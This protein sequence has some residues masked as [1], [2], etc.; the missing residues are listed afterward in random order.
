LLQ[1]AGVGVGGQDVAGVAELFL[2]GFQVGGVGEAGRPVAQV[3]QAHVA[4]PAPA[5]CACQWPD[6]HSGAAL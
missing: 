4:E 6:R 1:D 2:H 3:V 5:L